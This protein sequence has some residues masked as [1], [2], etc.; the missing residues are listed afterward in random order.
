MDYFV[1]SP[2]GL[3]IAFLNVCTFMLLIYILLQILEEKQRGKVFAIL[4]RI[5]SPIL[6]PLRRFLQ[7]GRIDWAAVGVI[8]ILQLAAFIIKKWQ[9]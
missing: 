2:S 5:F 7:A 1:K 9:Y 8:I 3:I 4:D 6:T